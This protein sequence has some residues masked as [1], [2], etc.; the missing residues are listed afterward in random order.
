MDQFFCG[1]P[2]DAF[3]CYGNPVFEGFVVAIAVL[4]AFKQI[5]FKHESY[6]T[7]IALDPLVQHT[8]KYKGLSLEFLS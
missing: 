4:L 8:F 3:I 5:A 6:N 2:G 7:G 1:F